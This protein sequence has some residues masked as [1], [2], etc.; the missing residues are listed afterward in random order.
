MPGQ[1]IENDTG[2]M[3]VVGQ[4]LGTGSF[5][6]RQPIGQDGP[7]DIYHLPVTTGLTFQLALNS[8]DRRGQFPFLERRPVA[9]GARFASQNRD[10]V[11]RVVNSFAAFEGA[12]VVAD[13]TAF[14]PALQTVGIGPDLNGPAHGTGINRVSV[15]VEPHETGLGY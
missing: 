12:R 10:V 9:Q 6:G 2:G 7:K 8:S 11:Q 14:L 5:D 3:N 4:R 1:D 13:N 15:V